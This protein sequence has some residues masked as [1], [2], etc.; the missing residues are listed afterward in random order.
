MTNKTQNIIILILVIAVAGLLYLQFG[1]P[2]ENASK[3]VSPEEAADLALSYINDNILQGLAEASLVGDIEE[4]KGLYKLQIEIDDEE[5]PSYV[6]KDG[7]LFF[8]Q[9]IDLEE[10]QIQVLEEEPSEDE[11]TTLG[12]FSVSEDE[13]CQENDKPIVYFFGA[14]S[15]SY[16]KWEHPIVEKVAE[17]F[18]GYISFHN[19][20]DS[21]EDMD[22][23]MKY[24][25]GGIPTIVLGCRYYR[26]GSGE[27]SG[28]EQETQDLTALICDL[29][30]NQP[31]EV[32]E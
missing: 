18:A 10:P 13:V 6:T 25:T 31:A 9:G 1:Q 22:V 30:N 24:S 27:R 14:E 15:C 5:F 8:P 26:V 28:E 19:N 21:N 20:M 16:C 12:N 7:K 11:K 32:C 2:S 4:E 29:T 17:G 3:S 23:L